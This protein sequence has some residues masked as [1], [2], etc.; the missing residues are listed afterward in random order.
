MWKA[1]KISNTKSA[2]VSL[3]EQISQFYLWTKI[4]KSSISWGIFKKVN[5][6]TLKKH[7]WKQAQ[8]EK[9]E[10]EMNNNQNIKSV[11]DQFN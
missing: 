11:I 4:R 6:F 9:A 3:F 10:K 2:L 1:H 5:V 7:P 8:L